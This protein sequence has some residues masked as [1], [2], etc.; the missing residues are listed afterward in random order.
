V[1]TVGE[2]E[3]V[4]IIGGKAQDVAWEPGAGLMAGGR[5][6]DRSA[7]AV[8]NRARG[9]GAAPAGPLGPET[10][11]R[12]GKDR[13]LFRPARRLGGGSP[14]GGVEAQFLITQQDAAPARPGA[15]VNRP[16]WMRCTWPEADPWR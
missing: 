13:G 15:S 9:G 4:R 11:G 14:G 10:G 7:A 16:Q 3:R 5:V 6:G 12:D 2:R 8:P 1:A